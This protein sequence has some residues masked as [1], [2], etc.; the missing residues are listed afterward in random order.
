MEQAEAASDSNRRMANLGTQAP[1]PP[2]AGTH[3]TAPNQPTTFPGM[4]A[5]PGATT[6]PATSTSMYGAAVQQ[7]PKRS[8]A[9]FVQSAFGSPAPRGGSSSNAA[10]QQRPR[11][12]R[13]SAEQ[14]GPEPDGRVIHERHP[15]SSYSVEAMG[16]NSPNVAPPAPATARYEQIPF[17]EREPRPSTRGRRT[18]SQSG[19][20]RS[21]SG[22]SSH[23]RPSEETP[24]YYGPAPGVPGPNESFVR[25]DGRTPSNSGSNNQRQAPDGRNVDTQC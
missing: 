8:T 25:G 1:L 17:H 11:F 10:T 7:P 13:S 4:Q 14:V 20:N 12:P 16:G 23:S 5:F 3:L 6:T 24:T 18:T 19:S 9:G 15:Q 22:D 21:L 2:N